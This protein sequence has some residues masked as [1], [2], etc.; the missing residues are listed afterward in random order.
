[1][2]R[3][4]ESLP[5]DLK[6]GSP[7]ARFR[8]TLEY[9]GEGF[10]GWQRQ[11][12]GIVTVQGVLETAL[13]RL[14]GHDVRVLGAGRTDSGVHATG[15]VAHFDTTCPRESGV[16]LRALN[17]TTPS[18]LTVLGV[19]AV[20]ERFHARFNAIYREYFYRIMTRREAPAL[21]RKRIWHH[22]KPLDVHVMHTA[23]TALLGEHD[24]SAFRAALCQA[25]HPVRTLS[26]LD[27]EA[28]G[29]EI[30]IRVGAN[31]FLQHMVRNIVGTLSL[32]G[33]GE[34]P[35]SAV[36]QILASKDRTKAGPTAPPWG[37]YLDRVLY[38]D[39]S[40]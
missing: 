11:R 18:T 30:Y 16:F 17:A 36:Q 3:S 27:V 9:D 1:M 32:V 25:K 35:P 20:D 40:K 5:A 12:D 15:Q 38:G 23:G 21:E 13:A 7:M 10:R 19:K 22:P 24:F 34:W 14:C 8:M 2:V 29:S 39:G 28:V 6:E 4:A 26:R 31:A 37:L 33:R